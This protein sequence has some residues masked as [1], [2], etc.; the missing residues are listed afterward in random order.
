MRRTLLLPHLLL[1]ILPLCAASP[2]QG[3]ASRDAD[4]VRTVHAGDSQMRIAVV[5]VDDPARVALLQHWAAEAAGATS[6]VAGRFP[7][8]R[9]RVEI[10]QRRSRGASPV[11]WGQTSRR[12]G[13]AVLL[14]V[15]EDATLPE[16]RA[17][18]T[19]VHEFSHLFHPF[20]GR[21]GRWM[22]EGL[23][24]YY[25]NVLRA[26]ASLLTPAEAWRRLDAGFG[27][28]RRATTPVPLSSPSG[29]RGPMRVYWA[30]AAYWLQAE[31]A[32]RRRGSS[33]DAVLARYARCCLDG[34]ARLSPL[35]FA[36]ALDRIDGHGLFERLYREH[37]VATT[38]PD[39]AA[40]YA[41]LGLE[42]RNGRLVFDEDPDKARLRA[43]VM[44]D[45]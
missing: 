38:F 6:A 18:W 30:G 5:G 36:Q 21:E 20:L 33:L 11:P 29:H 45:D 39:L 34:N 15:R 37:A 4:A 2:P 31:L 12:D 32:L 7:L 44:R 24:S 28:G 19:A 9:A 26:R 35:A 25:Q 27:R 42:T 16:L 22:A 40:S 3:V 17:D 43:A 14:Y 1:A 13:V 10:R 23:A 8:D 41:A